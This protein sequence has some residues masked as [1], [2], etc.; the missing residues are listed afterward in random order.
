MMMMMIMK[1]KRIIQNLFKRLIYLHLYFK[2]FLF[3]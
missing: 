2:K 3:F 1:K